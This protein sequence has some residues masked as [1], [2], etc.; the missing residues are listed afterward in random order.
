MSDPYGLPIIDNCIVCKL[1]SESFFCNLPS[2][3]LDAF[4]RIKHANSYPEGAILFVEGQ[5]PRG[6]YMLCAGQ[7]KLSATARDGR[8][9]ILRIAKPGE[10]LGLHAT[11]SNQPYGLTAETLQP[12][13]LNHVSAADFM[14]FL[15]EHG[16]ACLRVA[17]HL[18]QNYQSACD[19]VRSLGLF[20]SISE[21]LASLML[22]WASEGRVTKEGIQIN[23]GLTQEEIAQLLGT[24]RESITREVGVLRRKGLI[25]WK[26]SVLVIRNKA[27]LESLIGG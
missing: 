12:S 1:R 18:S 2:S 23:C 20:H 16:D 6:V 17:E 8:T 13:Q 25:T 11:V 27:G 15:Q 26:G 19:T 21:R 5:K 24:A 14:K 4:D 22:Q 10:L 9:I 3:T 7:V